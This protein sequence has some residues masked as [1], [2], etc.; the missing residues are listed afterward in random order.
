[1]AVGTMTA[2]AGL[3]ATG[4]ISFETQMSGGFMRDYGLVDDRRSIIRDDCDISLLAHG[5]DL[6][7]CQFPILGDLPEPVAI[8]SN[9][10]GLPYWML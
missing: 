8:Q 4:F 7:G 1:M 9:I 3:S 6:T 5:E 10:D 2:G